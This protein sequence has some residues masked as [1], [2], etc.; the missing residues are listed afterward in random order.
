[1]DGNLLLF[2]IGGGALWLSKSNKNEA[3]VKLMLKNNCSLDI[4]NARGKLVWSTRKG[5]EKHNNGK[6]FKGYSGLTR[7]FSI[8]KIFQNLGKRGNLEA[9]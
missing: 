7:T 6:C 3:G 4:I 8:L 2:R 9:L 1:M 5:R